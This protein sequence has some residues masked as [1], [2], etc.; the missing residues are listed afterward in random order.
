MTKLKVLFSQKHKV[1]HKTQA[2]LRLREICQNVKTAAKKATVLKEKNEV[3]Y[4]L[5]VIR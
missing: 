3:S 1:Y 4:A 2:T 5:S